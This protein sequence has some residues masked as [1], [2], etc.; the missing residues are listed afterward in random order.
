MINND[1]QLNIEDD[2]V[3]EVSEELSEEVSEEFVERPVKKKSNA[4]DKIINLALWIAIVALLIAVVLRVFV[5]STVEVSGASMNPTYNDGEV[6]T[7]NKM[8]NPARGD[9]VVFYKNEVDDKLKA[10][11]AK[12][13]ECAEGQP[14]EKLIKRV[15][16][17]AGDK[18]WVERVADSGGDEMYEVVIDTADGDRLFETYYVKKGEALKHEVYY[19]H[20]MAAT[21]LGE[22]ANCTEQNPYVVSK[23]CFFAMGDNR[24]N[25]KDSRYFGE[26]K[27]TQ[28]FGV[29]LDK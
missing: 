29:V 17:L 18:I 9:V 6:V 13:E 2:F 11:F 7:V 15:I 16:G 23:G 26:F 1:E 20:A 25:S 21:G 3:E 22:L 4:L 10:Q 28:L 14:Y 5:F 8:I 27:L 12:R 24:Q 19:I